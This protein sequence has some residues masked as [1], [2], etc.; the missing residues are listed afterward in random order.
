[1]SVPDSTPS[2]GPVSSV[3]VEATESKRPSRGRTAAVIVCLVLAA[4]LTTPA[5]I[6]YW[7]QRTLNDTTRYVNT[8]GP[9][10]NSPEV[11][12]AIATKVT[13]TIQD[14]VDI[15]ALLND[16]FS[17]V[18]T[19]R[20]RLQRLVGPL[21]GA[22]NS[23]IDR[24]V[25]EFLA[26]DAFADLWTAANTRAQQTLQRVLRGDQTGAVSLQGEQIVLDV[27][28][29]IDQVKQR[30][31][32]R[33]LTILQNVPIPDVDK[34]IVLVEAPQVKQMR[35][36]YAF[37]NPV[38]QWLIVVVAA[39]YLLALVLSR[40]RPRTTVIIG[41]LLAGNALLIALALTIGRQLFIDALSGTTFG[42]ASAVFY[43]QLLS[44]LERGRQVFF[45]LGLII[46]VMGWFAGPNKSGSAVRGA[47]RDGLEGIG[48]ALADGPVGTAGRWVAVNA[49][50]LRVVIGF[51]G[52]VVLL[53]GNN[54]STSRLFWSLALVA[55]LLIVVQ[56]LVGAGRATTASRPVPPPEAQAVPGTAN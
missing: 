43:D 34:Q 4:L 51:V 35:T 39:L 48:G 47:L 20:P 18:I 7:G 29:V 33:G 27:S 49:R 25:R 45:R 9:L 50:W 41:A 8:V 23:L 12:N 11:Q 54:I 55:L 22:I 30:L 24:Q 3:P 36:I 42:P 44:Y 38:A 2:G 32:D 37:A 56:V 15:E 19:D 10:V 1:M 13:D 16:V 14:Q 17:G 46:I 26:S 52:A 5:A 21:S 53:W 28:Q 6:A 31:V 40:R